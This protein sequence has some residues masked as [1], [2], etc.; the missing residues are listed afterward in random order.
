M[1]VFT[2]SWATTDLG[3]SKE[4]F[5]DAVVAGL[6]CHLFRFLLIADKIG[7]PKNVG[8]CYYCNRFFIFISYFLNSGN[9]QYGLLSFMHRYGFD[10]IYLWTIGYILIPTTVRYSGASLTFNLAE[11]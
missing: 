6:F 8:L 11:F 7:A 2:L 4:T 3:Y 1:T 10:G 5:I 9:T